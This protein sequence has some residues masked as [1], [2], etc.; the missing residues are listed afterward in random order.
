MRLRRC[1]RNIGERS[2]ELVL[3]PHGISYLETGDLQKAMAEGCRSWNKNA[4]LVKSGEFT[5]AAGNI[6]AG[7]LEGKGWREGLGVEMSKSLNT[8]GS[9]LSNQ[10]V[11]MNDSAEM[12]SEI[13]ISGHAYMK[14]AQAEQQAWADKLQV[15]M[16]NSAKRGDSPKMQAGYKKRFADA[17]K[18]ADQHGKDA[19]KDLLK[20]SAKA[21]LAAGGAAGLSAGISSFAETGSFKRPARPR[22]FQAVEL[23]LQQHLQQ[24]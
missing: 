10:L 5:Q 12:E 24:H 21:G 14:T 4:P 13:A 23:L 22:P 1:L 18:L 2:Y 3:K 19:T 7:M 15:S 8:K 17:Q 16:D 11:K 20:G 9:F 6:V